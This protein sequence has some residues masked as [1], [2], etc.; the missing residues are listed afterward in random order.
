MLTASRQAAEL[1]VS[2]CSLDLT[3]H[4]FYSHDKTIHG[5]GDRM[6]HQQQRQLQTRLWFQH[7]HT[8]THLWKCCGKIM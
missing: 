5:D 3:V 1:K 7:R 4:I 8:N 2:E 6:A